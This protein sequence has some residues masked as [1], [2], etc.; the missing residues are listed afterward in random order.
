MKTLIFM[1]MI[2]SSVLVQ[3]QDF[4]KVF[5][6]YTPINP[7]DP[8]FQQGSEVFIDIYY[9]KNDQKSYVISKPPVG[10]DVKIYD[11][12]ETQKTRFDMKGSTIF[13]SWV[14]QGERVYSSMVYMGSG[15]WGNVM[16]LSDVAK[17]RDPSLADKIELELYCQET[18]DLLEFLESN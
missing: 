7:M 6:C 17:T 3:A 10:P 8:N 18:R 9:S 14:T 16:Q 2:F 1:A 15:Q 12:E 4:E 5:R 13:L 11:Q